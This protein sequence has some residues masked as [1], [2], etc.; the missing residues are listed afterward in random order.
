MVV[1]I[2]LLVGTVLTMQRLDRWV[3][4][5]LY[6][7]SLEGGWWKA[8]WV[9]YCLLCAFIGCLG[10]MWTLLYTEYSIQ[11]YGRMEQWTITIWTYYFVLGAWWSIPGCLFLYGLISDYMECVRSAIELRLWKWQAE[12]KS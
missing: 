9:S 5:A 7:R 8:L 4:N 3:G 1:F 11:T 6:W 2:G 10:W 12:G